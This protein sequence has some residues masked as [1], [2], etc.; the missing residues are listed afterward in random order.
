MLKKNIKQAVNCILRTLLLTMVLPLVFYFFWLTMRCFAMDYFSIPTHSMEPTLCPGDKVFVNKLIMGARIYTDFNFNLEGME[1]KSFRTKGIRKVR[2][3][4]IVVFNYPHHNGMMSFII[5]NV[6]C[7]RVIAVPGDSIWT[8]DGYYRNNNFEKPLGVE[9]SQRTFS[10]TPDSFIA[11]EVLN[12]FPFDDE[13]IPFTTRNMHPVYVP[14]KGDVI[15]LTPYEA[16]YYKMIIEWETGKEISWD[17]QSNA[18]YAD[19]DKLGRHEFTH[20]YY[21][22]AGDNVM[23]SN[24]SRYW[25]LVPE[26][27]I[28][29]VV[30]YIFHQDN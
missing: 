23:D 6:Y 14:H 28:V 15:E 3:N 8:V 27:Y 22:L 5:N 26:D 11:K 17:W 19:G 24:D 2:H 13:H 1:L 12:T 20:D 29:G 21:F 25:G 16:A 10:D 7:K 18:V 4:D 30:G 9:S